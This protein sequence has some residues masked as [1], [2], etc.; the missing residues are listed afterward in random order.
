[1][2]APSFQ[3]IVIVHGREFRDSHG[4]CVMVIYDDLCIYLCKVIACVSVV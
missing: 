3:D 2:L 4:V 1:M